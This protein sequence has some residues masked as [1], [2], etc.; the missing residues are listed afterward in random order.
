MSV[1]KQE[2]LTFR[3]MEL[4]PL[5]LEQYR[6]MFQEGVLTVNDPVELL[7]GY[8]VGKDRGVGQAR[9]QPCVIPPDAPRYLGM[10]E[11]WPLTL[12]QYQQMI[13]TAIIGEDDPV[14]MM[15]GYLIAKDRGR[16]PGMGA[17]PQ[18]SLSVSRLL[19]RI[20]QAVPPPWVHR[21][22]DP[23]EIG[24]QNIA[25]AA[26]QPEPDFAIAQGPDDQYAQRYPGPADLWLVIEVAD[27][28]LL[29]DRRGKAQSYATAG[30]RL[31]WIVNLVDRQLEIFTDPD[32]QAGQYRSQQILPE[33]QQVTLTLPD[34]PTV[35]FLVR[36]FLP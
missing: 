24:P 25:G 32:T 36:D 8:L 16:G 17:G 14:E 22:Q 10:L 29:A 30:I 28:S 26:S 19:R 27:S 3:G 1:T 18:H 7:E 12:A 9:P 31:Y 6:R 33:D 4:M 21:C 34:L 13:R 23:I 2:A 5:S 15:A 11:I 35:T 20:I